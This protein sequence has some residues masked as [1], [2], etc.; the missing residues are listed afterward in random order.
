[1]TIYLY[2][3]IE[4]L[5]K[6]NKEIDQLNNL[7]M[8][9]NKNIQELNERIINLTHEYS[10]FQVIKDD[11]NNNLSKLNCIFFFFFK[12]KKIFINYIFFFFFRNNR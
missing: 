1:M 12:K 8:E 9:K 7:I 6:K 2:I 5:N 4:N 3:S 10:N 11:L